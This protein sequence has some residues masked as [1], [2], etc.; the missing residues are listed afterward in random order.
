M[1]R[2]AFRLWFAL[3]HRFAR[4][5]L[6][7]KTNPRF[8]NMLRH[9]FPFQL[10]FKKC[11]DD[12]DIRAVMMIAIF[13]PQLV[14]MIIF[15]AMQCGST[16]WRYTFFVEEASLFLLVTPRFHFSTFLKVTGEVTVFTLTFLLLYFVF[17]A[18][19]PAVVN[20]GTKWIIMKPLQVINARINNF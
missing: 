12:E 10:V 11:P 20:Y 3:W 16:G 1:K 6:E 13:L 17:S 4:S 2:T 5:W 18:R 15:D 14:W 19:M 7:I 9:I 8:L